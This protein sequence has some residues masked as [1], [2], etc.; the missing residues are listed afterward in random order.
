MNEISLQS[1]K[2]NHTTD[3]SF[4][5]LRTMDSFYLQEVSIKHHDYANNLNRLL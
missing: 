4:I 5:Q 1:A 3:I 2:R